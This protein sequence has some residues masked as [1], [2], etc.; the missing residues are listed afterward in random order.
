MKRGEMQSGKNDGDET[1]FWRWGWVRE[2]ALHAQHSDIK[3]LKTRYWGSFVVI[4]RERQGVGAWA[5]LL[6]GGEVGEVRPVPLVGVDNEEPAGAEGVEH[7]PD[8]RD[9]RPREGHVDP[10]GGE[11][12]PV[13]GTARELVSVGRGGRG[14]DTQMFLSTFLPLWR[15]IKSNFGGTANHT[16]YDI[17]HISTG[18]KI[19]TIN[20]CPPI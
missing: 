15:A 1:T 9:R 16:T 13:Q 4:E 17:R 12:C 18:K 3:E 7:R 19:G 6:V 2:R 5:P 8:V 20:P 10:S 14:V 11:V